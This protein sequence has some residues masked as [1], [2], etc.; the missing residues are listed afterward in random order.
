MQPRRG[1][2]YMEIPND[3]KKVVI[4]ILPPSEGGS[5]IT[6]EDVRG[7]VAESGMAVEPIDADRMAE[8]LEEG[9][10]TLTEF[11]AVAK[12]DPARSAD[13]EAGSPKESEAVVNAAPAI[14]GE[15]TAINDDTD[16]DKKTVLIVDDM[17]FMRNKLRGILE[18]I[19]FKVVGEAEDGEQAVE[20]FCKLNPDL[21]TMD[22]TMPKVDGIDSL[23]RIRE[24]K[25]EARVIMI[26][27]LG[28]KDKVKDSIIAGA[29]DFILKPFVTEKVVDVIM[30]VTN[31]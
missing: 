7:A 25:P 6:A 31:N 27:A 21:V 22:I 20:L 4:C 8:Y 5:P 10:R 13:V 11:V 3:E 19:N 17:K 12:V 29:M 1:N 2:I 9:K 30:R 26:S 24:T 18:T 15:N 28:Q 16:K 23:R 14:A